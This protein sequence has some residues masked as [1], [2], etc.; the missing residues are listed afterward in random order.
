MKTPLVIVSLVLASAC[1]SPRGFTLAVRFGSVD[2]AVVDGLR[3]AFD[4][5]MDAFEQEP[6]MTF[7][8][9]GIA[10]SVDIDGRYV[11]VITG[12]HLQE[13][14]DPE[15]RIFE[16]EMWSDDP[17]MRAGPR[18]LGSVQRQLEVI[19]D[20]SVFLPA[21]PPP[22]GQTTELLIQC[23]TEAAMAGRCVP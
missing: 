8:N 13:S 20:G 10:S 15:T 11:L 3:L 18:V 21:W 23:R 1:G 12:A 7:E 14:I 22:L 4:P 5:G 9:G 16:L 19:G 6:A 17:A 2:P